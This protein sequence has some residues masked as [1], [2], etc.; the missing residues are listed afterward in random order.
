MNLQKD[1][2]ITRLVPEQHTEGGVSPWT[3][4]KTGSLSASTA[5]NMGIWQKNA[6]QRRRNIKLESASNAKRKGTLQRTAKKSRQ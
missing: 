1:A 6:D 5:T 2:M 3:T 4:S